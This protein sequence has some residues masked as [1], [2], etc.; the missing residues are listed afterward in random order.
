MFEATENDK[1]NDELISIIKELNISPQFI[2]TRNI[3]NVKTFG[4]NKEFNNEWRFSYY[5]GLDYLDDENRIPIHVSPKIDNLDY[6]KMLKICLRNSETTRY[7]SRIYDIRINKP[8]IQPP[9]N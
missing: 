6:L 7:A 8:F 1:P 3:A 9:N 4:L 5:I 2:D